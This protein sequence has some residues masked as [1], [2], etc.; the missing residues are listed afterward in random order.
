M[1]ASLVTKVRPRYHISGGKDVFYARPPYLNKDLGAGALPHCPMA[2][3]HGMRPN[4]SYQHCVL[5]CC[6]PRTLYADGKAH[7]RSDRRSTG[8]LICLGSL[9]GHQETFQHCKTTWTKVRS[10]ASRGSVIAA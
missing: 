2:V 6:Q 5:T 8:P 7:A 10:D 4:L 9:W 3:L 1:V